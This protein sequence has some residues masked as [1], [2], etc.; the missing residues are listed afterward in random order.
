M[1]TSDRAEV[2]IL[3]HDIFDAIF[4]LLILKG[5]TDLSLRKRYDE[6]CVAVY[7]RV[8]DICVSSNTTCGFYIVQHPLHGDSQT[9]R[10]SLREWHINGAMYL[11]VPVDGSYVFGLDSALAEKRL[12]GCIERTGFSKEVFEELTRLFLNI[13]NS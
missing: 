9:A 3:Q 8:N 13:Y 1:T 7:K 12:N 11:R 6:A 4:S 2:E 10:D 5:Y